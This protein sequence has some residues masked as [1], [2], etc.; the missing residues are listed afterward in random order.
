MAEVTQ[1]PDLEQINAFIDSMGGQTGSLIPVLQKAQDTYGFLPKEV[2]GHIADRLNVPLA[3]V[4][5][6]ATFYSQFY[7]T[8]RGRT[9]I[10]LCDGTACHVSGAGKAIEMVQRQLAIKPGETTSDYEF[11]LEVVYCLGACA[12][13]PVAVVNGK[14]MGRATVEKVE[15]LL[16]EARQAA[17]GAVEMPPPETRPGAPATA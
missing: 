12:I 16:K 11:T 3:D 10:R 6:V 1:S 13:S 15:Q 17:P 14:V 9:I 8:R 4:V 2:L 5:G 7:L